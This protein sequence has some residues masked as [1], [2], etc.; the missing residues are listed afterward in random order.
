MQSSNVYNVNGDSTT[1]SNPE[2]IQ[3]FS[4]SLLIWAE[5]ATIKGHSF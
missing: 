3:F 2:S 4:I 5:Q 1:K